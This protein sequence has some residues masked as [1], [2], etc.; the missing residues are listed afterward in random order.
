VV[1]VQA[2]EGSGALITA[3]HAAE[4]GRPTLAVPGP[5]DE[6][7]HAGCHRLI[8][9]GATLCRGVEDVLEEMGGLMPRPAAAGDRPA[10]PPPAPPMSDDEGRVYGLL[11]GAARSMD[12]LVQATGLG[13]GKLQ[14]V[15]LALQMKKVVRQLPGNRFERA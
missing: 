14:G 9:D 10:S 3:G 7:Q 5:A 11:D 12:D 6:E 4:Q 1:I 8:R 2:G 13:V 15:L